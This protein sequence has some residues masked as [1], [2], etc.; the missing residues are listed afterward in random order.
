MTGTNAIRLMVVVFAMAVCGQSSVAAVS[1]E[2][3]ASL[4]LPNTTITSAATVAAGAFVPPA[5]GA[6][7]GDPRAPF[8]NLPAFC[9]VA[10]TLKPSSDSDI[11]MEVWMPVNGWNGDFQGNGTGGMGGALPLTDMAKTLR[12]GFATAGSDTGHQGDSRYVL[13][14]PE[15]LID[16]AYRAGHEMTL[17]AKAVIAAYYA[18]GAKL[19]FL[20]GCG[21]S[22]Q[23]AEA[24][25]QRYPTDYDGVAITGFSQKTRHALEQM[26]IYDANQ[27][28]KASY[29]PPEKLTVL[30]NAVIQACDMLDGVK[31]GLI[32]NPPSCKFDPATIQCKGA[33][34]PDCLTAVQVETVRKIYAGP[35]NP[36]T[37][38][39]LFYA[40]QLGSELTWAAFSGPQPFGLSADF[41]KFFVYKDGNWDPKVRPINYDRDLPIIET[42]ENLLIDTAN[43]DIREFA[44]RGGKL[45]LYEGWADG[46][47][48]PGVGINYYKKV[49]DTIGANA[50]RD[51]LR[52]FMVPGL[53]H[54]QAATDEFDAG[55]H[56]RMVTELEQWIQSK[57][58]P[59]R[60][61][62]SRFK[63]GKVVRTRPLCS[64]PQVATYKGAGSTDDA[65]RSTRSARRRSA[66][67]SCPA[68]GKAIR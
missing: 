64:Y 40:P 34:G 1:C 43:P 60:I 44:K 16:F 7:K 53:T 25:I 57:K 28:D 18:N 35:S 8:R 46:T 24:E 23:M 61:I 54:C 30:H 20:D 68:T 9:R 56:G 47:I 42:K 66:G 62:S 13:D 38:E 14:H 22:A 58:A 59:D 6:A 2:S 52:L 41:F 11:K 45:L 65:S 49:V 12:A 19:S 67:N 37:K 5:A 17:K 21:G 51:S 27:K 63:D 31:D 10:A 3:L 33:E 29:V 55:W 4:S 36:R 32:E 48:P 15:K 39:Q 50:A 26:W